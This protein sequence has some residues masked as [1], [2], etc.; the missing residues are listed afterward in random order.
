[1]STLKSNQ[2]INQ[3]SSITSNSKKIQGMDFLWSFLVTLFVCIIITVWKDNSLDQYLFPY[4]INGLGLIALLLFIISVFKKRF[5]VSLGIVVGA[6]AGFI[7]FFG[8][9]IIIANWN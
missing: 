9:M 7:F 6:V 8:H 3:P 5:G 4:F 2:S 1:M